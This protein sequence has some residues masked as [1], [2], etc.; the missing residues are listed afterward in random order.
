MTKLEEFRKSKDQFFARDHDSPLDAD[1]RKNF[2][3]L[4]YFPDNRDLKI[5]APLD[6][7]VEPGEVRMSTTTGGDQVYHRHGIVRF[8]IDGQPAQLTLYGSPGRH[9]LFLPFRDATAAT[10]TYA[11]GRYLDIAPPKTGRVAVDFNYAYSPYCAYNEQWSC[12][13]PPTENWLKVPI[14][15]GEKNFP[16]RTTH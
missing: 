14:R 11:A 3:G 13:L 4:A 9:E 8:T 12:P 16:G 1:Q 7:A 6:T 10:E 2:R 5:E 15:A